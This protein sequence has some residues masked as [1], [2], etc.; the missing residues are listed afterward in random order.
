M[1]KYIYSIIFLLAF[2]NAD[3]QNLCKR[4]ASL[5]DQKNEYQ[6][7][8]NST[9][10][11]QVLSIKRLNIEKDKVTLTLISNYKDDNS[12][13]KSWKLLNRSFFEK[14][15]YVLS[16][17]MLNMF[18][19]L[20]QIEE[21]EGQIHIFD[22]QFKN[23]ML[24]IRYVGNE[25]IIDDSLPEVM[26]GGTISISLDDLNFPKTSNKF[27]VDSVLYLSDIN[28]SIDDLL[29]DY[30]SKATGSQLSPPE[31]KR[32]TDEKDRSVYY[33]TCLSK[34]I[35]KSKSYY[36]K[37]RIEINIFDKK[38]AIEITYDIT[39][40]YASGWFCRRERDEF[41][42]SMEVRYP[43]ELERFANNIEGRIKNSLSK[44]IRIK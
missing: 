21:G 6:A 15:N 28:S 30:F 40:K 7:W 13:S 24:K 17:K 33:V 39:G 27:T 23:L 19:F 36:E 44:P 43:E 42:S 31:I 1:K 22:N 3:A 11:S 20:L 26:S 2:V 32:T 34:H 4:K 9:G 16:N 38:E 14:N 8:L 10:I 41:Y 37:V 18:L 29:R 12:F 5:K 25:I 35:L